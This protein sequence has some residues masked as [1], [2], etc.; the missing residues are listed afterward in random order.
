MDT[1]KT[2]NSKDE[3]SKDRERHLKTPPM[4][5]IPWISKTHVAL[6]RLT[7]GKI[8]SNLAGHPGILISTQGRRSGKLHTICLPY[9]PEDED[10]IV[11]G[12]YG[13]SEKDPD[14]VK[15]MK[16]NPE[17]IIRNK[18]KVFWANAKILP[19]A[20]HTKMWKKVIG[21]APWYGD[22]QEK[23]ERK[24]PLIRLSFSR[25]YVS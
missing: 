17:V 25:P 6:Y 3:N 14:W 9:V 10:M 8:G 18:E 2:M 19:A 21:V 15:N 22:Y 7:S 5:L 13:G 23:T 4:W 24:I 1:N 16:A 12:S 11:V 20:A